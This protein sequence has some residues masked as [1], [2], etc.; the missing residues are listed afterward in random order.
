MITPRFAF[1]IMPEVGSPR[2]SG[3]SFSS[4]FGLDLLT[5]QEWNVLALAERGISDWSEYL[6]K[7]AM[8]VKLE[9]PPALGGL[10]GDRS[11]GILGG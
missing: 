3:C 11:T 10:A 7:K 2:R 1:Q 8:P 4:S 6:P 5:L 9:G